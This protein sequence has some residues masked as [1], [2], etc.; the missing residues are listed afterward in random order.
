VLNLSDMGRDS[1]VGNHF[2]SNG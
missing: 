1:A 2:T